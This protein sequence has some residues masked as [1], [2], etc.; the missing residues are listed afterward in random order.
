ME[1]KEHKLENMRMVDSFFYDENNIRR[2][3]NDGDSKIKRKRC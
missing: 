1:D 3:N 2:K